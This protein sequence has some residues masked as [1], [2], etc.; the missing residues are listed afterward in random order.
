MIDLS[1]TN[2]PPELIEILGEFILSYNSLRGY[3]ET[4]RGREVEI[5]KETEKTIRFN[6]YMECFVGPRKIRASLASLS[7]NR[8][9]FVLP[10]KTNQIA[11]GSSFSSKLYFQLYQFLVKGKV[12]RAEP[13]QDGT[14]R[15]SYIIDFSPELVEILDDFFY[16]MDHPPSTGS[17]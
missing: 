12:E 9:V 4:F 5:D 8:L 10:A 3:F 2:Y 1:F 16:R 6:D 11:P 14:L 15:V 13:L 17:S 7:A